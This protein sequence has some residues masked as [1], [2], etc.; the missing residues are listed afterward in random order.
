ML[1]KGCHGNLSPPGHEISRESTE[2][3]FPCEHA[4]A[5][6]NIKTN[7]LLCHRCRDEVIVG[8]V[9]RPCRTFFFFFV[10][11]LQAPFGCSSVIFPPT[12]GNIRLPG[13]TS[14]PAPTFSQDT[15]RKCRVVT[16]ITRDLSSELRSCL[17]WLR[18]RHCVCGVGPDVRFVFQLKQK[19]SQHALFW[20]Y[21]TGL[22][23]SVNNAEDF[24]LCLRSV[25]SEKNSRLSGDEIA[26]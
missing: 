18:R 2:R 3:V 5:F 17:V 8:L 15:N 21:V 14:I 4:C 24:L 13:D 11:V 20:S 6:G 25:T 7:N 22:M 12:C 1:D 23:N 10:S 26:A 19:V 16:L 9:R